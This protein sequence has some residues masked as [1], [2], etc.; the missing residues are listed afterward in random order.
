MKYLITMWFVI[1]TLLIYGCDTPPQKPETAIDQKRE[2]NFDKR[3]LKDC[4]TL[5]VLPTAREGD[6]QEWAR[7]AIKIHTECST[8][9]A[10]ENAEIK[11]AL[12]IK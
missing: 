8:F 9:K 6:V 3:L 11:K 1:V 2:V 4:D 10:K 12:N 7:Q 5:P